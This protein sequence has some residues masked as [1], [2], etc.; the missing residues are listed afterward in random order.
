MGLSQFT[1][2]KL[3]HHHKTS[4]ATSVKASQING[5]G[6]VAVLSIP[7]VHP[8]FLLVGFLEG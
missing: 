5:L 4:E 3:L 7:H 8:L 6:E 1:F 2:N